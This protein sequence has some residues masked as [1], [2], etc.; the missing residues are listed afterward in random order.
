M[1]G[2]DVWVCAVSVELEQGRHC[3]KISSVGKN[4]LSIAAVHPLQ[5]IQINGVVCDRLQ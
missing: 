5:I 4:P 1:D 3:E 2:G